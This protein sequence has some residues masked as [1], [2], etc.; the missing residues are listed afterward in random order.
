MRKILLSSI[1]AGFMVT[2]T[3]AGQLSLRDIAVDGSGYMTGAKAAVDFDT[4][5]AK[6]ARYDVNVQAGSKRNIA[7]VPEVEIGANYEIT[8]TATN[9]T[10]KGTTNWKLVSTGRKTDGITPASFNADDDLIATV[11]DYVP[12]ANGN[13][14]SMTLTIGAGIQIDADEVVVLTTDADSQGAYTFNVAQNASSSVSIAVPEVK[15]DTGVLKNAPKANATVL[16]SAGNTMGFTYADNTNVIDVESQRT[17]IKLDGAAAALIATGTVS[18]VNTK[19]H[20]NAPFK[21]YD[22]TTTPAGT[23]YTITLEGDMSGVAGI[24]LSGQAFTVNAAAG[25]ATLTSTEAVLNLTAPVG[26]NLVVTVD[27]TTTLATREF[28][29]S[30]EVTDVTHI[31]NNNNVTGTDTHK[32]AKNV[33]AMKWDIN[34]YQA[35][36]RNFANNP[37]VKTSAVTLYNDNGLTAELTADITM[38]NGTA[39]PT[40]IL[41]N[42]LPGTRAVVTGAQLD[43]AAAGALGTQDYTVT[44]TMTVPNANGDC[45]AFQETTKGSRVLPVVDN[46]R[47]TVD[48]VTGIVSGS[49]DAN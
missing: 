28:D 2:N 7:Y 20:A 25:T 35:T 5:L 18:V 19:G 47:P 21:A 14:T 16:L 17:K 46:N 33:A 34:G 38:T 4:K 36:I 24:T 42:V 23:V 29:L 13:Y 31:D 40:I 43:T 11:S 12:D 39:I 1:V 37:G 41:P 6:N 22:L 10:F 3:F 27:G 49:N 15:S 32:F 48:Q 45:V 26:P 8:F 9:G 44:F 30:V